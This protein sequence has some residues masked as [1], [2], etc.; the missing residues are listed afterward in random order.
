M[1]FRR[2]LSSNGLGQ[3][4]NDPRLKCAGTKHHRSDKQL[5]YS[6]DLFAQLRQTV[7]QIE[8]THPGHVEVDTKQPVRVSSGDSKNSSPDENAL[9]INPAERIKTSIAF[10]P[11]C[12][13]RL[14]QLL[15]WYLALGTTGNREQRLEKR[16]SSHTLLLIQP[17]RNRYVLR[18][19]KCIVTRPKYCG[20]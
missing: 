11:R 15:V 20:A 12:R 5:S 3:I 2:S 4:A 19:Y 8:A 16:M 9:A 10:Q 1:Q 18:L 17:R 7:V 6:G 13:H 14:W